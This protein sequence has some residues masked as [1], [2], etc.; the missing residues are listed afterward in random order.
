MLKLFKYSRK[1]RGMLRAPIA[2]MSK[3]TLSIAK[4]DTVSESTLKHLEHDSLKKRRQA[5]VL[6]TVY[7]KSHHRLCF[8]ENPIKT[9]KRIAL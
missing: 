5:T 6:F 4:T 1:A 8:V 7:K 9:A 3:S 2:F